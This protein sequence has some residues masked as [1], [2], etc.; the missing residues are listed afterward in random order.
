[1]TDLPKRV[2]DIS[3]QRFGLLTALRVS[4]RDSTGKTTWECVCQ[5]GATTVAVMLN[6]VKGVTKSCGCLKRRPS[7]RRANLSGKRFGA[8]VAIEP[9][10]Q[11]KWRC[12]CDCGNETMV[13][14]VH[15]VRDHTKSCGH[16]VSISQ[17]KKHVIRRAR[18][19]AATWAKQVKNYGMCEACGSSKK[20]H[21]HHI[22]PFS[23][24]HQFR[25]DLDNGSCLCADCHRQVHK[26]INAGTPCGTAL[27]EHLALTRGGDLAELW[28]L[29]NGNILDLHRARTYIDKIAGL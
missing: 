11:L 8:L 24:Y 1:M 26:K 25:S 15:L 27:G 4:G 6:L 14:T 3:G 13:R 18:N 7:V 16:C 5:C 19:S 10:D 29:L 2:R 22:L 23:D 12:L 28:K 21:A 20:L 9:K 17:Q